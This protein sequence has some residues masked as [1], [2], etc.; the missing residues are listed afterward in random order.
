MRSLD[1][2]RQSYDEESQVVV[3]DKRSPPRMLFSDTEV[4]LEE[5]PVGTRVVFPNPPI[6]ELVNWRAAIR[7]A[8]NHPE[9]ADPLHAQLRPGMRVLIAIDDISLPLPPMRTPDVR[10]IILEIVLQLCADSGVD[11]VHLLIAN[12]LHRRMTPAEMERMVGSK[13]FNQY[14]PEQDTNQD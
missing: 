2:L 11:D 13:I 1:R 4:M 6:E 9:G 7:W 3:Q 14:H 12:A 10:Q 8:I 5:V